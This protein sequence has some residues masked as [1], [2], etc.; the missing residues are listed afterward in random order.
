MAEAG[1]VADLG[2]QSERGARRDPSEAGEGLDGARPAL[3]AG[4]LLQVAVERVKLAI[5][6]VEVEQHLL[7]CGMG[8]FVVEPLAGDP[9][10]VHLGPLFF[11][12]AVDPA[13]AQQ[14]LADSVPGAGAG[15][16]EI[17]AT[18][19]Q[20]P[21]PFGLRRRRLNERELPASV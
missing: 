5:E 10:P 1:E 20:V 3:P 19:H 8:E 2:D 12:L 13:V 17:V 4:D 15:A 7:E 14:L 11:A 16:A 9:R 21:E 18:A 6:S